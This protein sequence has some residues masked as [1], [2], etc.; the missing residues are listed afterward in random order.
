GGGAAGGGGGGGGGGQTGCEGQGS[1]CYTVY[2]H[3]N[4]TLYSVDLMAK[5][6][7]TVGKFNTPKVGSSADVITDLAVAPNDTIYVVSKTN[8]Y[9]ASAT[10]GHVTLVGPVTV[11]GMDNVAM[12][13]TPDG[14]LWVGDFRGAFCRIDT[15]TTPP[16]VTQVGSLG[17]G[18]ALSGDLVAVSDGTVYGTAYKLA[19]PATGG[20]NIDNILVKLDTATGQVTSAVGSTGFPKLFGVSYALGKVFAFTHDGSGD[21]ITVDPAT[22]A[23]TLFGSF[24][25]PLTMKGIA[26]AGA[27]V[28]SMVPPIIQ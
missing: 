27:G 23:G 15:A 14:K 16:T 4:D 3:S 24:K 19:D 9:T 13:T 6:L 1:G 18:M 26:F 7:I 20:S 22:G 2:A 21:V 28:N 17:M 8:L 25:D 10:D 11:C 12:T 5:S